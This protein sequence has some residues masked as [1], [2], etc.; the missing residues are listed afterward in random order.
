M[1]KIYIDRN[2]VKTV[3]ITA[4][5]L[6]YQIA[7]FAQ[8]SDSNSGELIQTGEMGILKNS[9]KAVGVVQSFKWV[10]TVVPIFP[11]ILSLVFAGNKFRDSEYLKGFGG[12]IGAGICGIAS[13]IG[14]TLLK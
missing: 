13:F 4:L 1:K 6:S 11:T 8:G 12:L 9:T 14:Y 3:A 10:L 7:V 2:M 5:I